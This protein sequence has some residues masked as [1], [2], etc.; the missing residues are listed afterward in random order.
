[1]ESRFVVVENWLTQK[2]RAYAGAMTFLLSLILFVMGSMAL[3]GAFQLD[4]LLPAS[5]GR[6]FQNHEYWRLWSAL[7]MHA[8]AGHLFGNVF[9]LL[10]FSYLLTAYYGALLFPVLGI[11]MGGVVNFFVVRSLPAQ[12]SLIGISGVVYWVAAAWLTLFVLVDTRKSLRRRFAIATVTS[13][14]LLFPETY[15]QETSY[16]SH[17]LGY[18]L[19]VISGIIFY[20]AKRKKILSKEVRLIVLEEENTCLNPHQSTDDSNIEST[21]QNH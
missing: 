2:P 9:L 8:D 16:Y 19:G 13:I 18:I 15:K 12:V 20:L 11:L 10:P 1:M 3:S 5:A 21:Q 7:F 17:F 14:V 6:I 4:Q